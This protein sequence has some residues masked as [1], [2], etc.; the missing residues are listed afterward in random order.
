MKKLQG[1]KLMLH[2]ETMHRLES[3]APVRGAF[4]QAVGIEKPVTSPLCVSTCCGGCETAIAEAGV[5]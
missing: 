1:R 2:R 5:F 3:L 4:G